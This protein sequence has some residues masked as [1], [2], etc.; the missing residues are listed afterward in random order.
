MAEKTRKK[1]NN[2]N[3]K[4]K[5]SKKGSKGRLIRNILLTAITILV[6]PLIFLYLFVA[7]FYKDHFYSNTII[8]GIDISN[9]TADQAKDAIDAGVRAYR[10]TLNGRNGI[11][12]AITADSIDLHTEFDKSMEEFLK[13]QNTLTWP[14]S[15][16][17]TQE[18]EV[19]TMLAYDE[20]M[21]KKVF[22][23]LNFFDKTNNLKPVNAAISLYGANGYEVIPEQQGARVIDDILYEAVKK[24]V[25]EL[26]PTLSLEEIGCYEKPE[27]TSEYPP[28][29]NALNQ[30]NKLAGAEITYHFGDA[31]EVLNG[32]TI[33]KWISVDDNYQVHYDPGDGIKEFVDYIGKTYNT[34]GKI[35]TFKTSYGDVIDIKGGDYGW[36]LNRPEEVAELTK[37]VE[38]GEK[39][40]RQP[41]YYQ[42]AQQYGDD[43]IGNT[44]VEINLTAQHLFFYNE[45]EL[46]LETDF[47]SGNVSKGLG[48]PVGTYP[49]QYKQND[50]TLVGEDYAT[51][52]KYWMPFNRNIGL[53]DASWRKDFGK[54][55]YLTSGSHGCI[56]MP[57]DMAK[58]LFKYI[59]RGVAVVVYEL[60]GTENY[61]TEKGK[62]PDSKTSD[63][64]TSD[65]AATDSK[66]TDTS[67]GDNTSTD[68]TSSN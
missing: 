14:A 65:K 50:A 22:Q 56:N 42:T 51:P 32:S 27:I 54:D 46:I 17:E 39:V 58:K 29:I 28:L 36:W 24:A 26:G 2:N 45:G 4:S 6:V 25:L 7:D 19:G 11:T 43:D 49:I 55:I 48:T 61:D 15:Y 20:N 5:K 16:F 37:L 52:V 47:V 12:D 30:M 13:E 23:G 1:R 3:T 53:H 35:R 8:N 64:T 40:E 59:H 38:N 60:P 34:F 33:S 57:P 31:T 63:G 21:L 18:L 44:Y 67:S 62:T 68:S 9:M 66:T 41:V 10:L